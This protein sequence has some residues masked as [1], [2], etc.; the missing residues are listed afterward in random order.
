MGTL[1]VFNPFKELQGAKREVGGE[2]G[3]RGGGGGQ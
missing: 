3:G 1:W 2:N